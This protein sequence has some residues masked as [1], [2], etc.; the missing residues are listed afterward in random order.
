MVY[1]SRTW[2][3]YSQD[4]TI[5][6]IGSTDKEKRRMGLFKLNESFEVEID[7]DAIWTTKEFR[8]ILQRDR[9]SR[10][11]AQGRK[12]R[13]ATKEFS[14]IYNYCDFASPYVEYEDEERFVAAAEGAGLPQEFLETYES[15]KELQAAVSK[16]FALRETRSLKLVKAAY[17]VIDKVRQ[18][19]EDIDLTEKTKNDMYV[20]KPKDIMTGLKDLGPTL[21]KLQELEQTVKKELAQSGRLRG[22][23]EKGVE[24]DPE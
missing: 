22:G 16:Y 8:R 24:E 17:G 11:D 15:D 21:K 1:D 14:F 20:H 2:E 19:Y 3:A 5:Y 23:V 7:K 12:K 4:W 18:F 10:G 13:Q 9:G 6:N